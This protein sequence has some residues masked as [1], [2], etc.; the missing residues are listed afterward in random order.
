GTS[1]TPAN[2]M[3][4]ANPSQATPTSCSQWRFPPTDAPSPAL[5]PTGPPECGT[6]P[7]PATPTRSANPSQPPPTPCSD[8]RFP[9][10]H[11]PPPASASPAQTARLWDI[12]NRTQPHQ[13]GQP[14]IGHTNGVYDLVFSPDGRTLVTGSDDHTARLWDISDPNSPYQLGQPPINLPYDEV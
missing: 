6:S 9:P 8:W 5:A 2:P 4:S 3:R 7:T 12:S 14:L 11:P 1:A 13:L 10:P